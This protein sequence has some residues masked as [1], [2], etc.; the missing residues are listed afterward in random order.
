MESHDPVIEDEAIVER[1]LRTEPLSENAMHVARERLLT[2]PGIRAVKAL[3]ERRD[4][5]QITYDVRQLDMAQILAHLEDSGVRPVDSLWQRMRLALLRLQDD[6]IRSNLTHK[7]SCCSRPPPG[8]G[9]GLGGH[10]H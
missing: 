2:L 1:T 9:K 8:A 3:E 5:L 4:K 6:N 7:P 10:R